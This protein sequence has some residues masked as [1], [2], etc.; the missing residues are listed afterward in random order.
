MKTRTKIAIST[1]LVGL[2]GSLAALG[3]FGEFSATTQNAGNE[4][5]SGTVAIS[6]NSAGQAMFN[7][8][9]AT[10]GDSWTRCIKVT[11]T[12]GLPADVH[13]YLGGTPGALTP[14]LNVTIEEGTQTSS[15]FPDCTGFTPTATLYDGAVDS[16]HHDW[17]TGLPTYPGGVSGPWNAGSSTVYRVTAALSPTA[18]NSQQAQSSGVLSAYW[19]ARNR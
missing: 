2:L 11:Y 10:P 14:Y 3:I 1:M 18:P 19:E 17:A 8:A 9:G 15:T 12:G 16:T 6:N 4:L 7:V 5:T 13:A